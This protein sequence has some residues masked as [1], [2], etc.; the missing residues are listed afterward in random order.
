MTGGEICTIVVANFY[1]IAVVR[2][3]FY[4]RYCTAKYPWMKTLQRMFLTG[5]KNNFGK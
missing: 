5:L 3:A 2:R 1:D 4:T